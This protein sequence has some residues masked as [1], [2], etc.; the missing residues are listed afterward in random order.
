MATAIPSELGLGQMASNSTKKQA[1]LYKRI[2]ANKYAYLLV[3]PWLIAT[4]VFNWYPI[5]SSIRYA[6]Y[7]W[8]GFGDPD[9]YVGFRFFEQ[10]AA[11]PYFW[12]AVKNAL[13]YTGILV[14]VQLFLAL[15]LAVIL[16]NPKLR[17]A[18]FFRAA[19]FIPSIC[20]TA[21]LAVPIRYLLTFAARY[22]PH[23]FIDAGVFNPTSG[24]LQDPHLA[25]IVIIVFGTWQ[26]VGYNMVLF[27][28]ALQSVPREIY[29]AA[30]V[31]GA[32]AVQKFASITL[33]LIRPVAMLIVLLAVLGSMRVFEQV[34]VLTDGGPY[35]ATEVPATYIYHWAFSPQ[36]NV[37]VNLGFASAAAV[38]YSIL[39]LVLVLGQV[40]II[41][42][43]RAFRRELELNNV[44]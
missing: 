37:K 19:F 5:V 22:V 9:Q 26:T 33:P 25:L 29:E 39:L 17:F 42:R 7:N 40:F 32:S 16:N 30:T 12:G 18:P 34:L 10:I 20:S 28:A 3:A 2:L 35:Y 14:P 1:P 6:F 24:F 36:I 8:Q 4:L 38:F 27:L 21:V 31:D 41:R 44:K 15:V 13:V 11:D 23:T 43:N